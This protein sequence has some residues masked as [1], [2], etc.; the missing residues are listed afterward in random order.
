[1][2][3]NLMF[4]L[5]AQSQSVELLHK[6]PASELGPNF[7]VFLGGEKRWRENDAQVSVTYFLYTLTNSECVTG[8][9]VF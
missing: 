4:V 2:N 3:D 5:P 6:P 1:M 9:L 7:C 8:C